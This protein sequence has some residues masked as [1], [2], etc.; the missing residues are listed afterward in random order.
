MISFL[1][2]QRDPFSALGRN[3]SNRANKQ[4][5]DRQENAL[6]HLLPRIICLIIPRPLR[7]PELHLLIPSGDEIGK[8]VIARGIGVD[9]DVSPLVSLRE[10]LQLHVRSEKLGKHCNPRG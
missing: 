10:A 8:L 9:G 2:R 1:F 7:S 4:K 5:A 3:T 6:T